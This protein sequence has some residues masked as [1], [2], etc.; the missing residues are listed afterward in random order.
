M[1]RGA[2]PTEALLAGRER[3]A[4]R[5]GGGGEEKAPGAG[6]PVPTYTSATRLRSRLPWSTTSQALRAH[7]PPPTLGIGKLRRRALEGL[8]GDM[9]PRAQGHPTSER[10]ADSGTRPLPAGSAPSSPRAKT[11]PETSDPAFGGRKNR[12]PRPKEKGVILE[13]LPRLPG[14]IPHALS[15]P[16][17]GRPRGEGL[18]RG[19]AQGRQPTDLTEP[20][21][22]AV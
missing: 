20:P 3:G 4:A 18:G 7:S 2:V 17:R 5:A 12:R 22:T 21:P 13:A 11:R 19:P 8:E 14:F 6:L 16:T 15:A 10:A 9:K 1:G